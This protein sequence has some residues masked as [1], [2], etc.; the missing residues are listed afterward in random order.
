MQLPWMTTMGNII[1]RRTGLL[2]ED[3]FTLPKGKSPGIPYKN[4]II[5]SLVSIYEL[6]DD[7]PQ[8]WIAS[9]QG[10]IATSAQKDME[11][12]Y[13][14]N[15]NTSNSSILSN[16]I[17][18]I[19]IGRHQLRW[20]GTDKGISALSNNKWLTPAYQREYPESLFKK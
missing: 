20:F 10:A 2:V 1:C 7:G 16:N 5:K 11:F 3:L 14:K 15:Y 4:S 17:V 8:F 13:V 19:A 18:S 12:S 6:S 9:S